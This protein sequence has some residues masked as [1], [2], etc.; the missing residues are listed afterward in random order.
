MYAIEFETEVSDG[1]VK[2]PENYK[3][4]KNQHVRVVILLENQNQDAELHALSNHSAG[5]VEDWL[6]LTEDEI[7]R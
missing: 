4:T 7:W 5:L 3:L 6:D 1:V 2:I